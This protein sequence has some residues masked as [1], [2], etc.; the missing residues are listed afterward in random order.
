MSGSSL[1]RT[2]AEADYQDFLKDAD[3][4][5]ALSVFAKRFEEG[6]WDQ[7]YLDCIGQYDPRAEGWKSRAEM[8][9]MMLVHHHLMQGY[10]AEVE[11]TTYGKTPRLDR[12]RQAN[13]E[14]L[15]ELPRPFIASVDMEQSGAPEDGTLRWAEP[16]RVQVSTA[17]PYIAPGRRPAPVYVVRELPPGKVPLEIGTTDASTTMWHF[18]FDGGV[19]RWPY[20]HDRIRLWVDV[21][22]GDGWIYNA[23]KGVNL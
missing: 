17:V 22:P 5:K 14:A 12:S 20:G 8:T 23:L 21:R 15:M 2:A 16:I 11:L 13:A 19:A 6:S 7:R 18:R 3:G 9:A 1:H 4:L 10:V